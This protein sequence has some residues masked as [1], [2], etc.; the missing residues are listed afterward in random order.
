MTRKMANKLHNEDE[1][2]K[3][4][5][6]EVLTVISIRKEGRNVFIFCDDGNEY[7]NKELR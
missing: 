6:G 5:T 1:V 7:H 2:V 3:K 4:L